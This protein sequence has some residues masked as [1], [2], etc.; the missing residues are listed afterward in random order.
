MTDEGEEVRPLFVD[1]RRDSLGLC[2]RAD[3]AAAKPH[4][5]NG[6]HPCCPYFPADTRGGFEIREYDWQDGQ[7]TSSE[8]HSTLAAKGACATATRLSARPTRRDRR[9]Y[10][11]I[12]G[13]VA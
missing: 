2:G 11:Q 6:H 7:L 13:N 4:E 10:S 8:I 12:F 3:L 9:V 5:P 1:S